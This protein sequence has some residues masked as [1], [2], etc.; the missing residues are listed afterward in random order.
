[1]GMLNMSVFAILMG[2][3]LQAS[4]QPTA[5]QVT[6]ISSELQLFGVTNN[7]DAYKIIVFYNTRCGPCKRMLK[8]M[9]AASTVLTQGNK[10]VLYYKMDMIANRFVVGRYRIDHV[11]FVVLYDGQEFRGQMNPSFLRDENQVYEWIETQTG[12]PPAPQ[13]PPTRVRPSRQYRSNQQP[14]IV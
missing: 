2:L 3:V 11:P 9:S 8:I 1:M 7:P 12:I 4:A 14:L 10:P 5:S 13:A 6:P